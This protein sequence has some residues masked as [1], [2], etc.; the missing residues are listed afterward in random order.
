M[1]PIASSDL[2][3]VDI[4]LLFSNLPTIVDVNGKILED[5]EKLAITPTSDSIGS[6]FLTH[7]CYYLI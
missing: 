7:V 6:I 3:D 4:A 5:L 2:F 1:K